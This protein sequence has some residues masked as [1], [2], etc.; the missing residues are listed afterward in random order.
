MSAFELGTLLVEQTELL[1]AEQATAEGDELIA[2]ALWGVCMLCE[3][4]IETVP[5]MDFVRILE[6]VLAVRPRCA[7]RFLRRFTQDAA[8]LPALLHTR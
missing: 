4:Q 3:S 5:S 7:L 2:V 8:V 6:K 1:L